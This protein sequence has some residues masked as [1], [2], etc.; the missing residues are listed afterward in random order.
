LLLALFGPQDGWRWV[1]YVNVPIGV[2]AL[3]LAAR[4]LPRRPAGGTGRPRLDFAGAGLLGGAVLAVLFPLV[5]AEN[6]GLRRLSGLVLVAL[7]IAATAAVL[8][9]V[10]GTAAG[11]VGAGPLLVAGIGGGL[12]ISPNI[13]LTLQL[14]PT[15]MAG[16]AGGALQTGQRIGAAVGT[17]L[18]ASL[19]YG[20]LSGTGDPHT[21]VALALAGAVAVTLLAL[22]LAVADLL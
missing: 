1:F 15:R 19:Y 6:G 20:V 12:V 13:T 16:A 5:Q 10:G 22:A 17:A 14:V 2:L 3:V 4:L 8:A 21:A 11:L 9:V 18:L 7:G